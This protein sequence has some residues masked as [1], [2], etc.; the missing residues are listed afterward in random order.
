MSAYLWALYPLDR[1]G[2]VRDD[3]GGVRL[4]PF[5]Y[6]QASLAYGEV[7]AGR[8]GAERTI[9]TRTADNLWL[10]AEDLLPADY[11]AERFTDVSL[12]VGEA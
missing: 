2:N 9:A 1:E 6:V 11:P 10:V 7:R 3:L 12:H 5:D 4:G 8:G